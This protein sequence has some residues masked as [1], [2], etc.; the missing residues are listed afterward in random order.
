MDVEGLRL[1]DLAFNGLIAFATTATAILTYLTFRQ[2]TGRPE[3]LIERAL[4][5]VEVEGFE[6]VRLRIQNNAAET[7]T[8]ESLRAMPWHRPAIPTSLVLASDAY[9]GSLIRHELVKPSHAEWPQD[10]LMVGRA[11]D[12]AR[13]VTMTGIVTK[14]RRFDP[15]S[16]R[17]RFAFHY[18]DRPWKRF[19]KT[20]RY[21]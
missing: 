12:P 7:L 17:I 3:I 15:R 18:H 19:T 4:E 8:L 10:L 13:T 1:I 2:V 11:V 21:G 9:G 16:P 5:F 14:R 6:L 20:F